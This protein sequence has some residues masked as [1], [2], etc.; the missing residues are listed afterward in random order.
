MALYS[1]YSTYLFTIKVAGNPNL[2][3]IM[4]ILDS[5]VLVDDSVILIVLVVTE[6]IRVAANGSLNLVPVAVHGLIF[7]VEVIHIPGLNRLLLL[8]HGIVW[9]IFLTLVNLDLA[10]AELCPRPLFELFIKV[11][12]GLF[13]CLEIKLLCLFNQLLKGFIVNLLKNPI[14]IRLIRI[15][16]IAYC[17]LTISS[18]TFRYG[19]RL[20][21][22]SF[23]ESFL[24]CILILLI[25]IF[26]RVELLVSLH[27]LFEPAD[28][29]TA[30]IAQECAGK[31]DIVLLEEVKRDL[32]E[33]RIF[34]ALVLILLQ[35]GSR[36]GIDIV[37]LGLCGLALVL[38]H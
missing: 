3:L 25:L 22:F 15:N 26:V 35:V 37:S 38:S 8:E 1:S 2:T 10:L 23:S 29:I 24:G 4:V 21:F 7:D 27:E 36:N 11:R 30:I 19:S 34:I 14:D 5:R 33:A 18:F 32:S 13:F 16:V 17:G 31:I 9:V 28:A 6:S 12:L 20:S